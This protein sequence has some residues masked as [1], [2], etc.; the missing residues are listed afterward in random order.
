MSGTRRRTQMTQKGFVRNCF[1][2]PRPN[3]LVIGHETSEM[4]MMFKF[5]SDDTLI[6]CLEGYAIIPLEDY[7]ELTGKTIYIPSPTSQDGIT[8]NHIE[9][10]SGE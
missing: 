5:D 4:E 10:Y 8:G 1:I 7:L 2:R 9:G 3:S 6:P